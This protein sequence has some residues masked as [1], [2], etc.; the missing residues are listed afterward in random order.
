MSDGVCSALG[1]CFHRFPASQLVSG[2]LRFSRVSRYGHLGH[3]QEVQSKAKLRTRVRGGARNPRFM[4]MS[5]RSS[6]HAVMLSARFL[7]P[8]MCEH[9][10]RDALGA[11]AKRAV[12]HVGNLIWPSLLRAP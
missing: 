2:E 5:L 11:S 12:C 10:E 7:L 9:L 1:W 6:W 8:T 3:Y 4:L